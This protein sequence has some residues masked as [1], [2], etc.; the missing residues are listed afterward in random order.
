M[1]WQALPYALEISTGA[2]LGD[3][4]FAQIGYL[5]DQAKNHLDAGDPAISVDTKNK[6]LVGLPAVAG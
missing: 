3:S 6:E 5:N 2:H 1:I 4:G